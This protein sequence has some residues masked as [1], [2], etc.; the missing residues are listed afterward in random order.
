MQL[1]IFEGCQTCPFTSTDILGAD[2]HSLRIE[3]SCSVTDDRVMLSSDD[4]ATEPPSVP[5]RW[6]P[7][8][9]ERVTVELSI[10]PDRTSN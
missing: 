10:R 8:R 1:I 4:L 2:E 3:H 7:M 9:L 5:P 6:C